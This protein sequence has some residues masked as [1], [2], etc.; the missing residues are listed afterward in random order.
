M[1]ESG[2]GMLAHSPIPVDTQ[3]MV[4][5]V[6]PG[7][8]SGQ[9]LNFLARVIYCCITDYGFRLGFRFVDMDS[10]SRSCIDDILLQYR[11]FPPV[12]GTMN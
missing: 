12:I 9:E 3:C 2:A 7:A 4:A 11:G 5:F 10:Y 8:R 1:S 6:P